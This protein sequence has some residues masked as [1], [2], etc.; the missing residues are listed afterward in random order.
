LPL[1]MLALEMMLLVPLVGVLK[2]HVPHNAQLLKVGPIVH[3]LI[4]LETRKP[5]MLELPAYAREETMLKMMI[6]LAKKINTPLIQS[7]TNK[8]VI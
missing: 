7:L 6:V 1:M 8:P 3:A 5:M 4:V 2:E